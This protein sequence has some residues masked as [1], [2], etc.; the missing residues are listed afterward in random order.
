MSYHSVDKLEPF[1]RTYGVIPIKYFYSG[2][3]L[4]DGSVILF[5]LEEK[6]IPLF[7]SMFLHGGW[8]HLISNM[9]YLWIFG[10]NVE[11]RM[12]HFRY[13]LFYILCGLAAAGAHIITN[14]ESEIPTIGA[15]GAIA[16]VLG[17]YM[18]LYP[19]ARVIVVIPIFF[20]W[21]IIKLPALI[22]LGF[23]FV[24][25]IFQGTLALAVESSA[26][27][28]VAGGLIS[29]DLFLECLRFTYL[30]RKAENQLTEICG[31]KDINI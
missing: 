17:G 18:L 15:S 4:H 11:D 12:G 28:G 29:V 22:V 9:L 10:D 7:T 1:L 31:G 24:T 13:I 8:L 19:Y 21:D 6:I 26:T 23:W 14:P 20:F 16:G 30:R 5:S 2:I 25:Q 27:G 3:K